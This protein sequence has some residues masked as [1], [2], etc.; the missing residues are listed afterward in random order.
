MENINLAR[1]ARKL[2][3]PLLQHDCPWVRDV[4]M[5]DETVFHRVALVSVA[6]TCTPDLEAIEAALQSSMLLKGTKLIVLIDEAPGR[7]DEKGI[8]WRLINSLAQTKR[9]NSVVIDARGRPGAQKVMQTEMILKT[10]ER[11]WAEYGL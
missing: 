6:G 2:L 11:R 9:S 1:T 3:L 5:P 8:Y 10:I 4:H 7:L